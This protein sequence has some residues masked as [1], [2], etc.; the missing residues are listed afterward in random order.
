MWKYLKKSTQRGAMMPVCIFL[1][2]L[3]AMVALW[4][5]QTLL[6]YGQ[7]ERRRR[8]L[9]RAFYM[10]ESGAF[11]VINWLYTP[12][13]YTPNTSLFNAA[14]GYANLKAAVPTP[15]SVLTI[16]VEMLPTF[17]N[18]QSESIGRIT[19]LELMGSDE[20]GVLCRVRSVGTVFN[21]KDADNPSDAYVERTVEQDIIVGDT[22]EGEAPGAIVS[23]GTIIA[24]GSVE[25]YWGEVWS[26]G[27]M[28]VPSKNHVTSMY[29]DS[30]KYD[31]TKLLAF[32]TEGQ[33]DFD[34][35]WK[36]YGP[37]A[38][39]SWFD[40]TNPTPCD[41]MPNAT[42]RANFGDVFYQ[43]QTLEFPEYPYE[44]YKNYAI[45]HGRYYSTDA[46]GNMYR[47]GIED[48]AH[49]VTD[50]ESEFDIPPDYDGNWNAI[51][52][53]TIDGNPPNGDATHATTNVATIRLSGGAPHTR[54]VFYLNANVELFGVGD[55]PSL[56]VP[57][58]TTVDGNFTISKCMHQGLFLV[59][60]K[61]INAGN[62][63][64]YGSVYVDGY[65]EDADGDGTL[66]RVG[67]EGT[68]TP[69]VYYDVRL[70]DGFPAP[71]TTGFEVRMWQVY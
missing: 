3:S 1:L 11:E 25:V 48:A 32:R 55:P 45:H 10:A 7:T 34:S 35:T 52:V 21:D 58:P 26:R 23:K 22:E 5:A 28:N 69:T 33:F 36:P 37:P 71:L 68:G 53:D 17:T 30:V 49:R 56:T 51:F 2:I 62:M 65:W 20:A 9:T 8:E 44:F 31:G 39:Q 60:G 18:S 15:D 4:L 42:D 70:G 40:P 13:E 64:V 24:G 54:G 50:W 43:N 6:D 41:A 46:A 67:Y 66:D 29:Y 27:A 14:G 57:D 19:S 47:D 38:S 63:R 59:N 16:P 61:M 12:S